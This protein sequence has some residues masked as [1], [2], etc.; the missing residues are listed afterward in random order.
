MRARI[1][2]SICLILTVATAA[3][4]FLEDLCL[5]RRKSDGSLTRCLPPCPPSTAPNKSCPA[6]VLGFA[7]IKPGQ[8]VP[9]TLSWRVREGGS[10]PVEVRFD[11][12]TLP[13]P[14]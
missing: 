3:E 14:R 8:A 4:A 5:P 9:L 6:Q 10:E 13:L 11:G 1:A 2:V 12:G 7:T